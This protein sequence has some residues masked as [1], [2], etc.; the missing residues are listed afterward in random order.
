MPKTAILIV[1]A[2][3]GSRAGEGLP[4][5]YRMLG[6]KTVL[7][8]CLE[9]FLKHPDIDYLQVVIHPDDLALYKASVECLSLPQPVFGGAER[10]ESVFKG[11]QALNSQAPEIVLIHDAARPFVPT[12]VIDRLAEALQ[13][14]NAAIPGLAVVDTVKR[15]DETRR[16]T[17]TVDRRNLFRVQTPQAFRYRDILEAHKAFSGQNYTDDSALFEAS[18]QSVMIVPGDESCMKLTTPQ[19]FIKAQHFMDSTLLPRIGSGFDVHRFGPGNH[20]TL[21][22]VEIP[23]EFGLVGHSD[24]DV[25]LHALTDAILGAIAAGDI[26][27]HFPP[28][29]PKWR[30]APS[31]HFLRHAG[32]LVTDRGGTIANLDLTL[33]CQSPKIGP[34]REAMSKRIAEILD[35]PINKISVKATTTEKLGF[36]GREEGIA[37]QAVAMVLAP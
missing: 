10:Q 19:D 35:L 34:Y 28:S 32:K 9:S 7:R 24:A 3:R 29:D 27:L 4:K 36:T 13:S 2:G 18:G 8:R 22:G 12:A 37:A 11:L 23:H 30:G 5:Q 6:D 26:G 16:I 31:D 21:C 33:I 20:V 14:Q 15:A 1:A 17:D 25:G